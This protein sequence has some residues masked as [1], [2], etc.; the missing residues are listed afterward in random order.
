MHDLRCSRTGATSEYAPGARVSV[1]NHS[2]QLQG[3]HSSPGTI[4]RA[5]VRVVNEFRGG[6]T[7]PRLIAASGTGYPRGNIQTIEPASRVINQREIGLALNGHLFVFR[8][9]AAGPELT[10]YLLSASAH[11]DEKL[12]ERIARLLL[13]ST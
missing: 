7:R 3:I 6:G 4:E 13:V 10:N 8:A 2:F 12:A 11:R 5:D 1:F 9:D